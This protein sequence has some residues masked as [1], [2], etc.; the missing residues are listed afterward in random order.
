MLLLYTFTYWYLALE[1]KVAGR[2]RAAYELLDRSKLASCGSAHTHAGTVPVAV[3]FAS[4]SSKRPVLAAKDGR[5]PLPRAAV[6]PLRRSTRSLVSAD[7]AVGR[8]VA[9]ALPF[10]HEMPTR[11]RLRS[12]SH[13]SDDSAASA[14]GGGCGWW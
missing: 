6:T 2:P 10:C 9:A 7:S 5:Q 4:K 13:V 14:L 3:L 12:S 11:G 8:H 1:G